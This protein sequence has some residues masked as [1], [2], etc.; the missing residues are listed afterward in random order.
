MSKENLKN[1]LGYLLEADT[2]IFGKS[3][4][5]PDKKRPMSNPPE[6]NTP[7]EQK[8][9][10]K[11]DKWFN[12]HLTAGSLNSFANDLS[13]LIP[14]V[15][16]GKYPELQ[17]PSGDVYRGMR[18]TVDQLKSFLGLE[19]FAIKA[20]EY[21]VIN[22][23]GVLTPQKIKFYKQGKPLSS[24]SASADAASLFAVPPED[25]AQYLSIILVANTEDPSNK[26]FLNPDKITNSYVQP[27]TNYHDENEV[28]AIGPVKFDRAIVHSTSDI[29]T[30]EEQQNSEQE[31]KNI[32][33][34]IS[35][36]VSELQQQLI[37]KN[38]K[39]YKGA[40][41]LGIRERNE[42]PGI[43]EKKD[44]EPAIV[45]LSEDILA[46]LRK[47]AR[48]YK[49][50]TLPGAIKNIIYSLNVFHRNKWDGYAPNSLTHSE[51]IKEFISVGLEPGLHVEQ[52]SKYGRVNAANLGRLAQAKVRNRT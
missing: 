26:F 50:D 11:L 14:I 7:E 22:K 38:S 5:D 48:A 40:A 23:S 24:W 51:D 25:G 16:S 2:E 52:Q 36:T 34:I 27:I 19:E 32:S 8:F 12:S 4:N 30:D 1:L 20:D 49:M 3:F 10:N 17:P 29:Y 13:Q 18:L 45:S 43:A 21:K 15:N 31:K 44:I 35:N 42:S 41:A 33:N 47:K 37:N 6:K 46:I 9:V 39:I 28:I